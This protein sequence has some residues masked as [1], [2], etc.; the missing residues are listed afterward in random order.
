MVRDEG[1][2]CELVM[3]IGADHRCHLNQAVMLNEGAA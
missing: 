1:C 3:V 2:E